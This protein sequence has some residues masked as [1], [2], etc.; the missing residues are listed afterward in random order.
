MANDF[1]EMMFMLEGNNHVPFC[2]EHMK[3]DAHNGYFE[4]IFLYGLHFCMPV[5]LDKQ[6]FLV[7]PH[8]CPGDDKG[9]G[10]CYGIT[11]ASFMTWCLGCICCHL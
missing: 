2:K 3:D 9:H 10:R 7:S 4:R 8:N 11:T 5:W 1:F 6:R